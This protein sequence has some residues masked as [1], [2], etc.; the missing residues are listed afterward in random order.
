MAAAA[1]VYLASVG[2]NGLR[3]IAAINI[4]NAKQLM[5]RIDEV[6]GFDSPLFE[7]CYFNEFVISSPVRPEKLNKLLLKH[8]VIGGIPLQAHVPRMVDQ[9]LLCTTELHTPADHDRLIAALKEV[10]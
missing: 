10:A 1:V 5:Q 4:Q 9:M 6:Q 8:G 7:A 2:G 3:E